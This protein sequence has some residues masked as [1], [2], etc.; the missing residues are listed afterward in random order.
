MQ[1]LTIAAARD[2]VGGYY[3]SLDRRV[4]YDIEG[5][6]LIRVDG[7]TVCRLNVVTSEGVHCWDV[8]EEDDGCGGVCLRGEF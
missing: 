6:G 5:A 2:Y 3:D 1:R 8:F 4:S 7:S